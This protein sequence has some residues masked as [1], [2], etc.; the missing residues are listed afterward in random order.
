MCRKGFIKLAL[1]SGAD[2]IPVYLLGNTAVLQVFKHPLLVKVSRT[3]GAS[4]TLFWGR[5]GLPLP[6]PDRLVYLRGSPLG[7]P[8]VQYKKVDMW[9]T[10]LPPLLLLFSL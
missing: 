2:V 10:L 4:L 8:K 3:L 5:W 9:S 7:M 6:M 1:E